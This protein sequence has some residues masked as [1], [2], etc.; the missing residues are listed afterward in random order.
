MYGQP[1]LRLPFI[2]IVTNVILIDPQGCQKP[3]HAC[4]ID[5]SN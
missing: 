2:Y 4:Q 5:Y 1:N 3:F